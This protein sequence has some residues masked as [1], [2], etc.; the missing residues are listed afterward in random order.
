MM[1]TRSKHRNSVTGVYTLTARRIPTRLLRVVS[2]APMMDRTRLADS[3]CFRPPQ[4]KEMNP[5]DFALFFENP[6]CFRP[7]PEFRASSHPLRRDIN[8]TLGHGEGSWLGVLGIFAGIDLLAKFYAGDDDF[9]Q[10]GAIWQFDQAEIRSRAGWSERSG[11]NV[12]AAQCADAFLRSLLANV[13][14]RSIGS[15]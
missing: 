4:E 2:C 15:A 13:M 12:S 8:R 11:S 7:G 10:S 9:Q 5:S 6:A 14:A 3:G 1:P